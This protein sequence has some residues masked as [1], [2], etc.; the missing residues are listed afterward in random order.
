MASIL[1]CPAPS[2]SSFFLSDL[3]SFPAKPHRRK[4]HFA[5]PS[6]SQIKS[7]T[8]FPRVQ[9]QNLPPIEENTAGFRTLR[10]RRFKE[11]D[12]FPLSMPLH[13][14]NPNSILKDVQRFARQNELNKAFAI[15]EYLD[16]EGIPVNATTFSSLVAACIRSKSLAQAKK[17][18]DH[19]RING[20]ENNEFLCTKIVQ[21]Y[22]ACGS[23]DDAKKVLDGASCDSVYPWNAL[24][25]GSV[26]SG[27]RR[28][29]DTLD[30]YSRMRES[31]V[32]LN[33]YSF[34]CLIKSFAGAVAFRQGLKTHALLIKNGLIGSSILRT[35]LIDMYFKC[36]KIKLACQVFEEMPERDIVSWGAMIA[37]FAH[38]RLHREA[39]TYI[40]LM[41]EEGIYLNSVILTIIL[42]VV[43]EIR[44]RKLGKEVHAH[45]VRM[46]S[47]SK[48]L[49]IQSALIDM[50][51]KCGD[52]NLGRKVFWCSNE[53]NCVSWTALISGYISNNRLQQAL[54]LMIWMQQ[55]GLRPDVVTVATVLPACAKLKALKQGREI[56]GYLVK[57]HML[58]NISLTTSL[59]ILYSKCG[60]LE[61]CRSLF[62]G[63]NR[64]NEISWT[65]MIDSLAENGCLYEA[66]NVFRSMQLSKHRPDPV[67]MSRV[68]ILC[69]ELWLLKLGKETHGQVLKKDFECDPFISAAIMKLYGRCG[70]IG[71]ANLVFNR[72]PSHRTVTWTA[73][74]E[75]CG[76]NGRF[77][78]A[79][80]LLDRMILE[81]FSPNRVTFYVVLSICD[82]AGF[83]DEACR[84]FNSMT[85]RFKI[86]AC[87]EHYGIIIR[88]LT[89]VGRLEEAEMYIQRS[90]SLAP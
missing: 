50:Y 31:G 30:A 79:I 74:I 65:A 14:K 35:S 89:R 9:I 47:Y 16:Q 26:V 68:L 12:A 78:D 33:V 71:K 57:N 19:I 24:L 23:V 32:E 60:A 43:G 15:L 54:K 45:V 27:G 58:P 52:I 39:L 28:C 17:I 64:R 20:L 76:Y 29:G 73:M 11:E 46:K 4:S 61:Y 7:S 34:S 63:M 69:G 86:K 18:H 13:E 62:E 25:R 48:E 40:R 53:R 72:I 82:Q 2:C 36:G 22:A 41:T 84:V 3:S 87:E 51:C 1:P 42:P 10:R 55:E 88:I 75:V 59:M 66:L 44:A 67:A 70:V 77:R 80:V 38:N 49:F 81:G 21:M 5:D 6:C 83:A 90:S 56:H 37:G 85:Q 8:A